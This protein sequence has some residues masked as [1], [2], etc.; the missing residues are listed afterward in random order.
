ME[1][2]TR[3]NLLGSIDALV[4]EE[5]NLSEKEY[6]YQVNRAWPGLTK[7]SDIEKAESL[8]KAYEVIDKETESHKKAIE[9]LG[10][11]KLGLVKKTDDAETFFGYTRDQWFGDLKL[12][13]EELAD[14]EKLKKIRE[15]I[16]LLKKNMSEDDKFNADMAAVA[17]LIG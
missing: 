13:A 1:K 17:K 15:A 4:A 9:A 3:A 7:I 2:I 12:C 5:K 6:N 14:I 10:L 16:K 11:D 8:V